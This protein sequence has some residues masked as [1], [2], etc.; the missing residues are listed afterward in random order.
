MAKQFVLCLS[1]ITEMA[2]AQM[3]FLASVDLILG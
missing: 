2:R 3:Q 1:E